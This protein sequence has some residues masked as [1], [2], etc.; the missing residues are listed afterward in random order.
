[1][2]EFPARPFAYAHNNAVLAGLIA[3]AKVR[4][5][6]ISDGY[7]Y[8]DKPGEYTEFAKMLDVAKQGGR[9]I[10]YLDTVKELAGRSLTDFKAALTAVH[11]AGMLIS[12]QTEPPCD[13][14][15][16]MAIIEALEDLM[17]GYQKERQKV[18]AV[19]MC[20]LDVDINEICERTGLN[21]SDVFQ[22]VADYKREQEQRE[23]QEQNEERVVD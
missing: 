23:Q 9:D 20:Q 19:T 1:M 11:E 21:E 8:L 22:A 12:S 7:A 13:F 6:Y 18:A 10:L 15:N 3:N 17:P 2:P 4:G 16:Y 5:H 14:L